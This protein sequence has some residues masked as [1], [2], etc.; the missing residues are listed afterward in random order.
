MRKVRLFLGV[1]TALVV[2]S[3]AAEVHANEGVSLLVGEWSKPET[4]SINRTVFTQDGRYIWIEK[5]DGVWKNSFEGI[6][7]PMEGE[8]LS[9][10]QRESP[11]ALNAVIVAEG[12]SMGGSVAE[13]HEATQDALR[14]MWNV[15]WSE[16]LSF[17]NPNDAFFSFSR[18]PER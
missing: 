4:C 16:D 8:L 17:E 3:S 13:V 9:V 11:E 1:L 10:L 12:P 15:K 6:Y 2:V 7:L 5:K 14:G 18:C